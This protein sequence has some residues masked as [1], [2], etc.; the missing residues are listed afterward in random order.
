MT[1]HPDVQRVIEALDSL[2]MPAFETLPPAEAR[3]MFRARAEVTPP[4]PDVHEV[5]DATVAGRP[6][7][8]YRPSPGTLPG[9]VFLHGGGWVLGDLDT[10]DRVCR[11]MAR[12]TGAT[13]VAVDY[14]LAPEHPFPAAVDDAWAVL[15]AV[16]AGAV[17]DVDPGRLVVMGDSAGGNLAAVVA[18]RAAAAGPRLAGQVL[19]YP[20]CDADLDRRSHTELAEGFLLT[21]DAMAWFWDQ[22]VPDPALRF[23][24]DASPLRAPLADLS[25]AAPALVVTAEHDPLRDEGDAYAARL[26]DAGVEVTHRRVPGMVHGFFSLDHVIGPAARIQQEVADWISR[27]LAT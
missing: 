16:G 13:V 7:R 21:R 4:G 14:R 3:R 6:V 18:R 1:V 20:V 9:V 26:A 12:S 15:E 22:Y 17:A 2:G 10:H 27:R 5:T 25:G 11:I 23:H 8:I 24:P 19:I